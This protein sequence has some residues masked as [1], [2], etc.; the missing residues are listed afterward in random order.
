MSKAGIIQAQ[1]LLY[2]WISSYE[3]RSYTQIKDAC[4]FLNVSHNLGLGERPVWDLF[5]PML[6]SGVIDHI[7]KEYYSLTKPVALVFEDHAYLLNCDGIGR[8]SNKLPV[9]YSEVSIDTIPEG[10]STLQMITISVL[11]SFPAV[12]SVIDTWETSVL[13][14]EQLTY[15]DF[16]NRIGV[17]EY[18]N[19]HT[20]YF[21][22]PEKNYLKEMPPR[23]LN[24][25]AYSIGM[26]YERALNGLGNG[27]Y[28][29]ATKE[30]ILRRFAFPVLL[31]RCL[32]IDGM[33]IKTF[34]T[35]S[36][37]YYIFKNIS[38]AVAKEINRILCKSIIYE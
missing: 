28:N 23:R 3:K 19:G 24:P 22:I 29:R 1:K 32:S 38:T 12:N 11:K 2:V 9:G 4:T 16:R 37:D 10:V 36:E 30:L 25:D 27:R 7:G 6:F 5:Y 26:S 17:A 20:R 18:T 15:H 13:D 14:E 21:S 34:P 35:S 33:S 8:S 31:Y